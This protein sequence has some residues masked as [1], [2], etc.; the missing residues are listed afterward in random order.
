MFKYSSFLFVLSMICLQYNTLFAQQA[1]KNYKVHEVGAGETLY[2]ISKKY[3]IT[4]ADIWKANPIMPADSVIKEGMLLKIPSVKAPV[5]APAAPKVEEKRAENRSFNAQPFNNEPKYQE[6]VKP[7]VPAPTPVVENKPIVASPFQNEPKPVAPATT[8]VA[9][10]DNNTIVHEVT[11]GQTLYAIAR[12]Y[13]V[14]IVSVKEWNN[15]PDY[16]VQF[17]ANLVIYL[18]QEE[19]E[20]VTVEEKAIQK[21]PVV[22]PVVKKDL[23][24][25]VKATI[26]V[27][28]LQDMMYQHFLDAKSRGTTPQKEK[29]SLAWL[30]SESG[31]SSTNYFA[32]HKTAPSGTIIK[33]TNLINKK[34]VFVKV[35]GKLPE[36][37]ENKNIALKVS[38]AA[39]SELGLG[40][41]KAYVETTYYP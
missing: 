10:N 25:P 18:N 6:I 11:E 32:L 14:D 29:V 40:G 16:N 27:N 1:E 23:P 24:A 41:E 4:I 13:G 30:K 20:P 28:S 12:K 5:A 19:E 2:G 15:L 38:P 36:N 33:I 3:N 7:Q 39:K 22:K 34:Y 37:S 31:K 9:N 21:E 35:I 8:T 26:Q 17:G